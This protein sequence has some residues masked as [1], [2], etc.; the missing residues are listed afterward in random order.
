[1]TPEDVKRF[2]TLLDLSSHPGW[3]ILLDEYEF[4]VESIKE[5]F[6]QF[7]L[8]A[9]I[10]AYG[11]GRISV[12]RELASMAP[13]IRNALENQKEDEQNPV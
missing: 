8:D 7:G 11:Q 10:L 4:K 3:A 9:G 2:E 12:Y 1:V 5:G 13:I 6:T